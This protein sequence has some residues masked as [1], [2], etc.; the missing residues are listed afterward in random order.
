MAGTEVS[1]EPKG[2]RANKIFKR[3]LK[4]LVAKSTPV[5]LTEKQLRKLFIEHDRDK[6]GR[7]N[8]EE[9]EAAFRSLGSR[10]PAWRADQAM[11][12]NDLDLDGVLNEHEMDHLVAYALRYGYTVE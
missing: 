9:L 3:M 2:C 7:L 8:K 1:A 11:Y 4:G 5:A 6:D 10:A 12:N